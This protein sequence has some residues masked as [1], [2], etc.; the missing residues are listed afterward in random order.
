MLCFVGNRDQKIFIKNPRQFSMQKSPS[1][2]EEKIHKMFLESG[3]NESLRFLPSFPQIL[4]QFW[5]RFRWRSAISSRSD[6]K[7]AAI[8]RSL[9]NYQYSTAGQKFH[10]ILAPLLVIFSGNPLVFSRKIITSSGFYRHCP[11]PT[12]QHQ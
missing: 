12:R 10:E 5:L 6:F 4:R 9:K 2:F 11:P 1:K 3:H 8:S 7:I